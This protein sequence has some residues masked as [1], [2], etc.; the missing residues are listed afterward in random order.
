MESSVGWLESVLNFF[1][2]TGKVMK[3]MKTK[4]EKNPPKEEPQDEK[5]G[6]VDE[7]KRRYGFSSAVRTIDIHI[8]L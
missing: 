8:S 7:I 3:Q 5:V 2:I 4:S 1:P 6:S